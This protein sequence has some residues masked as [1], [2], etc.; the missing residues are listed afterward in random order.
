[1]NVLLETWDTP[2][3]LP[4]FGDLALAQIH[5]A[6]QQIVFFGLEWTAFGLLGQDAIRARE[7]LGVG[8]QHIRKA[9][10]LAQNAE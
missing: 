4:P 3:G 6:G 7:H 2:F 10:V 5:D 1:M 8:R 9:G